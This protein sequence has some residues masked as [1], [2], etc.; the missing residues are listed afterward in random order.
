MEALIAQCVNGLAV[1]SIYALI[2]TGFNL[3]LLVAGVVQYSYAHIIVIGMYT[4][5]FVMQVTGGG[6]LLAIPSA[7]AVSTVVSMLTEPLFRPLA[8]KGAVN[9]TFVMSIGISM[10][11]THVMAKHLHQGIPISFPDALSGRT[12]AIGFGVIAISKGQIFVFFGSIAAVAAFML[13][14][15]RT[16]MGRALRAMAQSPI[17]AKLVGVPTVRMSMAS[18]GIA[19]FLGGVTAVFVAMSLGS[20]YPALA[21]SLGIKVIATVLFAGLGNLNGGL[22]CGLILGM[23]ESLT[24]GY[25]PGQ[26]S[27]ALAFAMIMVTVMFKPQGLF[28]TRI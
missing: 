13:L 8:R 10:I 4:A 15:Y 1:G 27:N 20:A 2:V 11:L 23:A 28:G 26:W 3:L 9:Q 5:W 22:V 14:L 16:M 6:L 24:T 17:I 18:Y 25:L 7:I 21:D 12:A 19:G